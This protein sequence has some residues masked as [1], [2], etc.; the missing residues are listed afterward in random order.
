MSTEPNRPSLGVRI[1][2]VFLAL[3]VSLPAIHH[4]GRLGF[5]H[6]DL[7]IPFDGGYRIVLGQLPFVD[8]Q[9][10][11]GPVLFLQ[12][13]LFFALFGVGL[14]AFLTHA[15]VLNA[16]ASYTS[17]R[18]L[19]PLLGAGPAV[20]G[21]MVTLAWF[22]LP[23]SA[24]YIDTTAFFWL[25]I[26]LAAVAS[27]RRALDDSRMGLLTGAAGLA[28][29]LAFLTKQN[30]GGLGIAGLALLLFLHGRRRWQPALLLLA[31]STPLVLL[32]AWASATGAWEAYMDSFWRVPLESGRLKYI[33][34]FALRAVVKLLRPEMVN[35]SFAELLGPALRETMVYG[36]CAVLAL[37]WWR[38]RGEERRFLL[39]MTTMLLLVQQ[40]SFNTSNN[41]E[42]LYWPFLGVLVA[43]GVHLLGLGR[44][45]AVL[46]L[47]GLIAAGAGIG[48]AAGRSIHAVKPAALTHTLEEGPFA[49]LRLHEVEGQALDSLLRFAEA[50]IPERSRLLI[51]GHATFLYAATGHEPPQPLLWFRAGVSYSEQDPSTVDDSLVRLL[52]RRGIDWVVLDIVGREELLVDFPGVARYL[53]QRFQPAASPG[54]GFEIL[55]RRF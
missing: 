38:E 40:W 29:G 45:P 10:P 53:E 2:W 13:A 30:I 33:L 32:T 12:Q 49:G 34:P 41:D 15:A 3:A 5:H 27:S 54:A 55:K 16:A 9:A 18:L 42:P 22:Y 36:L 21:G 52:E 35:S 1:G 48:L 20:L 24:P 51:L 19:H 23:P 37:R 44:R 47:T 7:S 4:F 43:L 26:A 50:E 31:A 11:I 14:S 25:L 8:F 6:E 17:W 39:A 28:A 46:A